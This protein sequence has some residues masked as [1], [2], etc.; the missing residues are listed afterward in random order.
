MAAT[1]HP[2]RILQFGEGNFLR[3]FFDWMLDVSNSKGVTDASAVIVSP[4]F[5]ANETILGL[6]RQNCLYHVCLEGV[7]HSLPKRE[8]RLITSVS[9][10]F[11]P[12]GDPDAYL[13]CITSPDLRFVVSNTTEAGICYGEDDPRSLCAATFPGKVTALLYRRYLHFGGDPSKGLIF[14]C[15]ELVEDNG[16]LLRE[17]VLRHAAEAGLGDDFIGWVR[18]CCIFCDTLVDRIVSGYSADVAGE[19]RESSGLEDRLIVKGE[20]YHLW[21]IG[22]EGV[23]VIKSELPFHE[24]GLN[25]HFL[26]SVREFRDRKVRILNGSHT[27]MVPV[28]LQLGCTT[29]LDAFRDEDVKAFISRMLGREVLPVIDGDPEELRTFAD[30][31]ME[32]FHNPYIRHMLRSI[33]LNSLSKWETRN[34]PTVRDVWNREGRHACCEL[35]TFAALLALYAPDSGFEPEDD[36]RHV[37]FIRDKWNCGD[38]GD[39]VSAVVHGPVFLED[40]E[41]AVPGF[42]D[43]VS[44]YLRAIRGRGMRTALRDFLEASS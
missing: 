16:Q 12:V 4:R 38:I 11:S 2:V 14:L 19:I 3:A 35:F 13:A 1:K 23:S 32:R 33:S 18:G 9:G 29:V 15:C 40:F 17:Y 30:G 26:P 42:C 28:A 5:K 21:V 8:T 7:E 39:C 37:G 34:F 10:A 25:V 44:D 6:R 22:G 43:K 20:L 24:A 41:K 31:I 36:P 27:G